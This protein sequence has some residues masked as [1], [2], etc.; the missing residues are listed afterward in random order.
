MES[1]QILKML[2][3]KEKA[4]LC[5][6]ENSHQTNAIEKLSIKPIVFRNASQGLVLNC[7]YNKNDTSIIVEKIKT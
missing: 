2:S 7:Q 4:L 3:T 1:E 6:T 5:F